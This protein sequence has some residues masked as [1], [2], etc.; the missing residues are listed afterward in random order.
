MFRMS[1]FFLACAALAASLVAVSAQAMSFSSHS[2]LAV[3]N[4]TLVAEECPTGYTLH[5]RLNLC[6]AEPIRPP[7]STCIRDSTSALGRQPALRALLGTRSCI[8][9]SHLDRGGRETKPGRCVA[10]NISSAV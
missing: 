7:R 8:A 4:V 10:R 9:A 6:V 3:P 1:Y 2:Q 5:P